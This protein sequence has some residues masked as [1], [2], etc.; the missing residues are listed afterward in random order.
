MTTPVCPDPGK[1]AFT[2]RRQAYTAMRRIRHPHG[3]MKV[4]RC[5]GHWHFGH[6]ERTR[7]FQARNR[8]RT[9]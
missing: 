7:H 3:R 1:H 4:Y 8:R 9:T 2:S 5:G 6:G